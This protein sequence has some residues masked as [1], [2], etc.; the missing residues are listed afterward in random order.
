MSSNLWTW[1]GT[2]FGY[3]E[4]DDLWTHNGRHVGR[5]YDDEVY[6]PDGHYLG[7]LRNDTRLITRLSKKG[8]HKTTF[9]T[10]S[11]RVGRVPHLNYIGY[12]MYVGCE[13]FPEP[14]AVS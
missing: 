2:Y 13:D 4:G 11:S 6:G 9:T 1:G 5:F 10:P 12:A 7:E 8:H 3:R 14:E